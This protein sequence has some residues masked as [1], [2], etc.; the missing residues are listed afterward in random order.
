MAYTET[1]LGLLGVTWPAWMKLK[2]L[3]QV[4]PGLGVCLIFLELINTIKF[5]NILNPILPLISTQLKPTSQ[6]AAF[7]A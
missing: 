7:V 5:N 1:P 2:D 4:P 3:G 6:K